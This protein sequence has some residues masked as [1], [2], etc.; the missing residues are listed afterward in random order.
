MFNLQM[1]EYLTHQYLTHQYLT[2]QLEYAQLTT[3]VVLLALYRISISTA[4]VFKIFS[5]ITKS[6]NPS[7]AT[8]CAAFNAGINTSSMHLTGAPTAARSFVWGLVLESL[9]GTEVYGQEKFTTLQ[10]RS[11]TRFCHV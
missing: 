1:Y 9:G 11:I 4:S 2:R 10:S 6:P 3:L 7:D 8:T 5:K